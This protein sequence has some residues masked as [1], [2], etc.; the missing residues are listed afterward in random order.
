[1]LIMTPLLRVFAV[2]LAVVLSGAASAD[3]ARANSLMSRAE[4]NLGAVA[5]SIGHLKSPP[6][7][8]KAKLAASRLQQAL[9]DLNPAKDLLE[10][11]PAGTSGRDEAV[12]RYQAAVAEYNRLRAIL[13]GSDAPA[14]AADSGDT[15]RLDYRQEELLKNAR[16]HLREVKGNADHLT[17]QLEELRA[18]QDQLTINFRTVNALRE[19][20]ANAQRKSGFAKDALGQLPE[21]GAGVAPVA[22][23]LVNADAK[24]VI[25]ADYLNPL[26]ATLQDLINPANYPEFEADRR[27]LQELSGMFALTDSFQSNRALAGETFQQ[28][29]AAK[30]ECIRVAQK[31]TRLMQQRTDQGVTIENVGNGF[32]R[33]H[34]EFLAAADA[35]KQALPGEI[36][37]ELATA[38]GYAADAVA[39]QKPLWFTGGIPQVMGFAE[40]RVAL[41]E[42]LDPPSGAALRAEFVAA[43]ATLRE[44][45]DSLRELIIRENK[46]PPDNFAGPDR[47]K[48]IETAIS[49]WKVQQSE[50]D[51][52]KI[53][54]PSENWARETKWTYSNRT[55]Y[56]SDKSRL[57][58]RL[59]VADHNNPDQ[60]IDRPINVWKD[61]QKGDSMYG[62]PLWAFEDELPPSS[63]MLRSNVN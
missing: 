15:V 9:D 32:L 22:Q 16:F 57:Q 11:V 43:E 59:L 60:V 34:A 13:V 30:A 26:N 18:V 58:V 2:V 55:W 44:Q 24:V 48:A 4:T 41:L 19:I 49:A 28:A 5:S 3:V 47:D 46:M 56:F 27:R 21:N 45:A 35:Q 40:E 8:A 50:F 36:R 63:F 17:A 62:T 6:K 10:K 42:V 52:L 7:G 1:M 39:E 54:I 29:E 37:S 20:V 51:V 33:R 53:R 14:P 23:E 31:Y 25:A 61:H 38:A 12:A